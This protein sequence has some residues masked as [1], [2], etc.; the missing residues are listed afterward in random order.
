MIPSFKNLTSRIKILQ[1]QDDIKIE[2][3]GSL[4]G[5]DVVQKISISPEEIEKGIREVAII[6]ILSKMGL[7][8]ITELLGILPY[9][10]SF[11][12]I[13]KFI[14]GETLQDK[15]MDL[16][17][18]AE[19]ICVIIENTIK[20]LYIDSKDTDYFDE[21][22]VTIKDKKTIIRL[23]QIF[24]PDGFYI[25]PLKERII[26]ATNLLN[27]LGRIHALGFQ[28]CDLHMG[29]IMI[30]PTG[31]FTVIDFGNSNLIE[32]SNV[33]A[34]TFGYNDAVAALL[35][36]FPRDRE[37]LKIKSLQEY[38]SFFKSSGNIEEEISLIV[39]K[40]EEELKENTG[41]DYKEKKQDDSED[42]D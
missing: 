20:S 5:I 23:S 41:Y 22:I 15:L 7:P 29:N 13:Y 33:L 38:E 40:Y 18:D 37:S 36:L 11:V 10:E 12:A 17:N 32:K 4:S 14:E 30:S 39:S 9:A 25:F 35:A 2:K 42:S 21:V 28:H 34:D 3:F 31:E 1:I 8:N 27:W 24:Q 6:S 16:I 19:P 26:I